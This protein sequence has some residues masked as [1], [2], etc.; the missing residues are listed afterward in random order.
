MW[1]RWP[2]IPLI[3]LCWL[4][5]AAQDPPAPAVK[6]EAHAY[7]LLVERVRNGDPKVDFVQLRDAFIDWR[8]DKTAKANPEA[9]R[10]NMVEAFEKQDYAKAAEL[11]EPV[12]V[13]EFVNR[14]LHLAAENAYRQIGNQQK[15]DQHK[16]IAE[17]LLAALLA[18]G[19]GKKAETAYRVLSI[20]EEYQIMNQL[21]YTVQS[22][23]LVTPTTEGGA[24]DVLSGI[25]TKTKK[26]VSR[27]FDISSFFGGCR[28]RQKPK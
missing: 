23:A 19:D 10:K 15:A 8:C 3:L 26:E 7:F 28:L 5:S 11:V 9:D 17:K 16:E 2:I 18:S 21:G 13:Y 4:L 12:L 6:D 24:Y 25:D 1:K 27:Y 22:Q 20:R 14:E